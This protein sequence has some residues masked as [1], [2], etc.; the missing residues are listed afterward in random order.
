MVESKDKM[1]VQLTE[2][3]KHVRR[4]LE[5]LRMEAKLHTTVGDVAS[6][7][8]RVSVVEAYGLR[9][10]G[11]TLV[12]SGMDWTCGG[13]KPYLANRFVE[14]IV[15]LSQLR[16]PNLVMLYGVV[17]DGSSLTLAADPPAASLDEYL[18]RYGSIPEFVKVSILLDAARGLLYLHKQKPAIAHT[19]VSTKSVYVSPSATARIGDVGVAGALGGECADFGRVPP[20][21]FVK[22]LETGT[23]R[24]DVQVDVPAFGNVVVHTACQQPWLDPPGHTGLSPHLHTLSTN[25]HPLYSLAYHCLLGGIQLPSQQHVPQVDMDYVVQS[26]QHA[27]SKNPPPFPNSIQLYQSLAAADKISSNTT[28]CFSHENG[29]HHQ[30]DGGIPLP[31]GGHKL[32]NVSGYNMYHLARNTNSLTD[33]GS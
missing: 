33:I 19:R 20:Q 4:R 21:V 6:S 2:N 18:L 25:H 1:S 14:E 3:Q 5:P 9:Y 24:T 31:S 12:D 17:M 16:H 13:K 23:K 26:L 8:I 7:R 29:I 10:R 30:N 28:S 11:G 27:A 15:R 32:C 22:I